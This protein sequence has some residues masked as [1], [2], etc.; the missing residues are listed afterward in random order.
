MRV[1]YKGHVGEVFYNMDSDEY[2]LSVNCSGRIL[3]HITTPARG[4]MNPLFPLYD[5]FRKAVDELIRKGEKV[6]V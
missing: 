1:N 4:G 2:R 3:T 6:D 5:K